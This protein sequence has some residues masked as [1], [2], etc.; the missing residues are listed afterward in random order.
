MRIMRIAVA[1]AS[2]GG[3]ND[4]VSHQFGRCPTFTIVDVRDGKIVNVKVIPNPAAQAPSGAGIQASQMLISE[5]V[6]VVIAG[7]FGPNASMVLA[8]AGICMVPIAGVRVEDAIRMF[9][10]GRLQPIPPQ[11]MSTQ[12]FQDFG[13]GFTPGFGRGFGRGLGRGGYGRG[14]G[15]GRKRGMW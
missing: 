8:Q 13:P 7:R 14:Q 2:N 10:E 12:Q 9:L 5:G 4:I 1:S 3:L 6:N 11:Y 15:R